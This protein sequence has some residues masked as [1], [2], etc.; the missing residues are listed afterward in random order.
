MNTLS[1]LLT[2]RRELNEVNPV[3]PVKKTLSRIALVPHR[4]CVFAPLRESLDSHRDS[5]S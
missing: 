3:N 1:I 2:D 5:A 4:D